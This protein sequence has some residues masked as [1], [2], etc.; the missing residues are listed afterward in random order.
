[1]DTSTPAR[2]YA[3][4]E[5]EDAF[6]PWCIADGSAAEQFDAEFVDP[7]AIGGYGTLGSGLW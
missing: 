3:I 1:V 7:E 6:C 2:S 4:E 5:L